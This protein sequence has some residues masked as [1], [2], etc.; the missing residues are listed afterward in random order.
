MWNSF[1]AVPQGLSGDMG[2]ERGDKAALLRF[3]ASAAGVERSTDPT[4]LGV[5]ALHVQ[6]LQVRAAQRDT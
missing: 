5:S 3:G 1:P 2:E 4:A 6:P